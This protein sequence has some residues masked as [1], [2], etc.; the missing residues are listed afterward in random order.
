MACMDLG[1]GRSRDEAERIMALLKDDAERVLA[2]HRAMEASAPADSC[3]ICGS[4][5]ELTEEHTP[6]RRAGN[7]ESLIRG[8]IDHEA[9]VSGG[10]VR[11]NVQLLQ[12]GARAVTLCEA[13][14]NNTGRWFNPAYIRLVDACRPSA[15]PANAGNAC[16]ITV[17]LHPQRAAKQAL[18]T[19]LATSQQGVTTRYP[20]LRE[21]LARGDTVRPLAP[22]R[23]SLYLSANK[24]A[25]M[26]GI[27][28]TAQERA[29]KVYRLAEFAFWPLGWVLTFEDA[30]VEGTVDVSS[31]VELGYHD[32][33][34]LTVAVP[35]QWVVAPY[36]CDFRAPAT[37][38]GRSTEG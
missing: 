33:Q 37:I 24:G 6:S 4:R 31:W 5:E 26:S 7:M 20:H 17:E 11:W 32:K 3:R 2:E 12:G 21:M 30:P 28:I 1:V 19:L 34:Q 29:R 18:T 35:C 8:M 10:E 14:N 16:E 38:M 25:R 22:L 15:I 23:L 13:C 36:P 9:S 27:A